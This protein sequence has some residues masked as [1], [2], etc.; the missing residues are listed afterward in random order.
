MALPLAGSH[1]G[2]YHAESADGR[3]ARLRGLPDDADP[4]PIGRG[5]VDTQDGPARIRAP[6]VRK[7]WLEKNSPEGA[8]GEGRGREPFV[9]VSWERAEELVANELRRVIDRY[10][11]RAIFAGSYGWASAGRFHHAQSQ[12]HRFLNCLGGYV[13]SVNTYS[14]ASAEVAV[15]YML[16]SFYEFLTGTSSWEDVIGNTRLLVAFGGIPTKN[17]QISSGGVGRHTQRAFVRR[18]AAAGTEFVCVS[19]ARSDLDDVPDADWFPLRPGTDAALLL[20]IAHTLVT[21]GLDDRQFLDRYTVGV[22]RLTS[23]LLGA[24]DGQEKSAEWAASIC[25]IPADRIRILARRMAATRTMLSV[26]WSLTRQQYGEHAYWAAIT[27]AALLGQIGLPG[28]GIGFGYSAT[29]SIGNEYRSLPFASLPQSR[30]GVSDFIPVARISDMLLNPGEPFDYDGRTHLYPDIRLVYWAG[31]NPFHHHQDLN[32][33][34]QAWQRP[35][36]IVVNE[37]C[38]TATARR[39]DIVLPCTT[40]LERSDLYASP[41]DPVVALTQAAREPAGIAR[42]DYEIFAGIAARLG[43]A[44]KFTEGRTQAQWI[45]RIYEASRTTAA[46]RGVDLPPFPALA[47]S[48]PFEIP[49][50][51]RPRI[52]LERFRADPQSHPLATESG[53]IELFS[54][55]L[56]SY[57]YADCPGH[58]AWIEPAEWLGGDTS[59][60]PLHLLTNQPRTRLHSQLDHGIYSRESKTRGRE[61]ILINPADAAER[62]IRNGD[63]VRLF[64]DRGSCLAGARLSLMVRPR[65]M[66]MATGA[67]FDPLAPSVSGSMCVHGNP[68]VLTRDTGATRLSQAPIAETCLVEVKRYDGELPDITVFSSPDIIDDW[69]R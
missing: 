47:A 5:M 18:A 29:N 6:M 28:G 13:R 50:Q 21:E 44:E 23:Y 34:C 46:E 7:G 36:T 17:G 1:W 3:V 38:W 41:R 65:V 39:A 69:S 26:S 11:N 60:Y 32:R 58:A 52:M 55:R 31:G 25:E 54:R 10:G 20:A 16:G 62:G 59:R 63:V 37:W 64:N 51:A 9:E 53:R 40:P 30:N 56:A 8:Q 42:D 61:P 2:L 15:P 14:F 48:G 33:L 67:W 45:E 24:P 12:L 49:G 27:V 57:G 35:E 19:P 43:M 22:D 4:S 66:L 68:N